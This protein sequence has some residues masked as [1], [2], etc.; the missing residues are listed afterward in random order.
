METERHEH[1]RE[2]LEN[3]LLQQ[4]GILYRAAIDAGIMM[5]GL[6][7]AMVGRNIHGANT[8]FPLSVETTPSDKINLFSTRVSL[9]P[10]PSMPL[11][12]QSQKRPFLVHV[13][14]CQILAENERKE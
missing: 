9:Y 10:T 12:V 11:I 4:S 3:V 1:Q 7:T 13:H 5:T 2:Q 6:G 8:T 14:Y